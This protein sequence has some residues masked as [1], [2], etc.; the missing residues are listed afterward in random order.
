MLSFP[1]ISNA[2]RVYNFADAI[3]NAIVPLIIHSDRKRYWLVCTFIC[4]L[5][6]TCT[7]IYLRTHIWHQLSI[8]C[9]FL[10]CITARHHIICN[11]CTQDLL[12]AST[13]RKLFYHIE[14]TP[15]SLYRRLNRNSHICSAGYHLN[16]RYFLWFRFPLLDSRISFLFL[17]SWMCVRV[18]QIYVATNIDKICTYRS[19]RRNIDAE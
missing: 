2:R 7:R 6:E 5:I 1:I 13:R 8:F 14:H 17:I 15:S 9:L 10:V 4:D 3:L 16:W 18:W 19:C 12:I 11:V